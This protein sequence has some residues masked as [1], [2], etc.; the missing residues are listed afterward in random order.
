MSLIVED[1]T[2]LENAD[3]YVSLADA[4]TLATSR[5]IVLSADDTELSQQLVSAADRVT[6]YE[7]QFT[8]QRV[9]GEQGLS[10]PRNNSFRYGTT[11]ANTSIP[12]ELKLAQVTLAGMLEAGV[13]VWAQGFDG[14]K[15]EKIGPL[16]IEYADD[17]AASVGNP[18]LPQI[19]SILQPLF[20][21][22]TANF[23]VSR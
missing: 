10:Y 6:S 21:P 22:F 14:V 9:T 11:I 1:G 7:G 3:S 23:I 12:K 15:S 4:R 13:E 5:G 16:Q 8:G 19:E 2:G 17:K 18:D 20:A